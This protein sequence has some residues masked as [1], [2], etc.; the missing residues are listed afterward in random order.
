MKGVGNVTVRNPCDDPPGGVFDEEEQNHD[1]IY[2]AGRL[3]LHRASVK[4]LRKDGY[5]DSR[6][7]NALRL[8]WGWGIQIRNPYRYVA[9]LLSRGEV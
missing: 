9:A 5:S 1:L 2:L 6:I 4:A 3:G 7:V 8:A